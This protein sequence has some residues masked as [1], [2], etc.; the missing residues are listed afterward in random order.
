MANDIDVWRFH[1]GRVYDFE[2]LKEPYVV[3][4]I[5]EL[6]YGDVKPVVIDVGAGNC[7]IVHSARLPFRRRNHFKT[8]SV[9]VAI[10]QAEDNFNPNV[11]TDVEEL[12]FDQA[13]MV[14]DGLLDFI[15]RNTSD[16]EQFGADLVVFSE[17]INYVDF[18]TVMSWFNQLLRPGG[19]MVVA[20]LPTRGWPKLFAEKGVKS[21]DQM[22]EFVT[23][24]LGHLIVS[25]AYPWEAT[26][27]YEGFMVLATQ[28]PDF[29]LAA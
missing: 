11:R 24:D 26:D 18:K 14:R 19:F 8:A 7:S 29:S 5:Q 20:N 3:P 13:P 9:D 4:V 2:S 12:V 6:D 1:E 23:K 10:P 28:K 17:I 22:L 15:A 25:Q 16:R 21:H 27:D